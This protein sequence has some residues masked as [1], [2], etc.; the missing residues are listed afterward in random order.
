[1]YPKSR[2]TATMPPE[3]MG[4]QSVNSLELAKLELDPK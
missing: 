1:M 3:E 2:M 4:F